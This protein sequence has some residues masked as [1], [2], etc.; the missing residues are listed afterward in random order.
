M[1]LVKVWSPEG[2]MFEV[3]VANRND[4]VTHLGWSVNEVAKPKSSAKPAAPAPVAEEPKAEEA[5]EE[6]KTETAAP[7][8]GRPPKA[9]DA[10]E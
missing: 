3:S 8:R 7:R 2:E 1:S 5:S 10:S 4:L 9:A 6:T